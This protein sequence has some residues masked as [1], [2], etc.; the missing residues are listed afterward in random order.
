MKEIGGYLEFEQ[1]ISNPYYKNVVQLNTGRN[2]LIYLIKAKNIKKI[3]LP[4][5]MCNSISLILRKYS[6][7]YEYYHINKEFLPIIDEK[8]KD[9]EYIYIVN[10]YGQISNK[11]VLMVKEQYNSVILDNTQAFFQKPIKDIDTIYSCR[12]YFGLPDG[13]YL[14]TGVVF[15]EKLE[16]DQSASRMKHILG[17][18]E[19]Q[20]SEYYSEF[21]K[22]EDPFREL[23]IKKMSKL[24]ENILGAID[25]QRIIE[26]RNRNFKI[27]NDNLKPT[28]I[29]DIKT[30]FG[31]FAYPY[32]VENGIETRKRL[33]EKKIYIPTL[34]PNVL[35]DNSETSIEFD[36]AANILPLPCDQ[37]YGVKEM[38]Y[39]IN[40]LKELGE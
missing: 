25:Y 5:F 1:L 17:R 8:A 6:I 27:L 35:K 28:N 34:W 26:L 33:A 36:Y 3:Y 10:Y 40:N 4:Y 18:F 24:T 22:N 19:R 11:K 32:Y 31:A 2:A 23:P 7:E 16:E 39:I 38:E 14:S 21:K 12:K 15:N 13:A 30:P 29:L 20:A 9:N 37:R